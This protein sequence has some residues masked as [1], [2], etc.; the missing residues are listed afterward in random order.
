MDK[1]EKFTDEINSHLHS[2]VESGDREAFKKNANHIVEQ[3]IDAGGNLYMSRSCYI[4]HRFSF[5]D[6]KKD[7]LDHPYDYVFEVS[8]DPEEHPGIV[9]NFK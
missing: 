7:L 5:D 3:V 2:Y 4:A 9:I 1:F 8:D 6:C